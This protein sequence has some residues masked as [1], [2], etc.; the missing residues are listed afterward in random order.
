MKRRR[1]RKYPA[2]RN[3]VT[4]EAPAGLKPHSAASPIRSSSFLV[5]S[6]NSRSPGR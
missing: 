1:Q 4:C 2:A 3:C 5:P 6:E